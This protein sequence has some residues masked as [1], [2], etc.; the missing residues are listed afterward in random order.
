MYLYNLVCVRPCVDVY[1]RYA[2]MCVR[3]PLP[4]ITTKTVYTFGVIKKLNKT[5]VCVYTQSDVHI[6][7]NND[8]N[9]SELIQFNCNRNQTTPPARETSSQINQSL[10]VARCMYV[11]QFIYGRTLSQYKTKDASS[12]NMYIF[13]IYAQICCFKEFIV[14]PHGR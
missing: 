5:C 3:P 14:I 4:C 6:Y 2:S 7:Y 12:I 1:E 9:C 11:I 13:T 10:I 8:N